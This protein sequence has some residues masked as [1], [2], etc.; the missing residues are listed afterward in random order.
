MPRYRELL[1]KRGGSTS[2]EIEKALTSF[3]EQDFRDHQIWF[4]LAWFDPD[5]LAAGP[6]Q[7]FV[8]KGRDFR[9]SD[10]KILF[11]KAMEI[12]KSVVPKHRKLQD[13]GRIE[14]IT[15][16]YAHPILP[17]IY[18][19]DLAARGDPGVDLPKRFSYPQDAIA[20]LKRTVEIY[21]DYYGYKQRGLWPAEGAVAQEI[22]KLVADAGYS[23][24]ASGE[25]VLAKSL[26]L[27][28]FTHDSRDTVKEA[29]DLYR[30]YYAQFRDGPEVGLV[31]RDIRLSD[32]I[33]FEYSGTPGEEAASDFMDR[34]DAIRQ[35][36]KEQGAAQEK[37]M[38]LL[39]P[40]DF[41]QIPILKLKNLILRV[42]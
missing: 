9:E 33:G 27:D 22:V 5:F 35:S 4:N 20:H 31:F 15:T 13:K 38:D 36:L 34:L 2:E 28:S 40:E 18:N 23:W 32:L 24:M 7:S 26:G 39:A 19:S 37:N 21:D 14:V 12:I 10:K 25:H 6:L 30:P 16:P 11:E 42:L 8:E 3:S 17:L 1:K 41:A 29:A